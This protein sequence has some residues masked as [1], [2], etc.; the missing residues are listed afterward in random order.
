MLLVLTSVAL[1]LT[2]GFTAGFLILLGA[3]TQGLAAWRAGSGAALLIAALLASSGMILG[4]AY[5][6]RFAR[7][8]LFG[9]SDRAPALRDLRLGEITPLAAPLLLI[10]W[11]GIAP[12]TIMSKAQGVASQLVQTAAT[13]EPRPAAP[14]IAS[15]RSDRGK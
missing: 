13:D 6:L 4:A 8:I 14:A 1:P 9:G 7:A 12:G 3:F 5:M 10:L 11:I 15:A 2:S